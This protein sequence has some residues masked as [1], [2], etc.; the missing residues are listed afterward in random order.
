MDTARIYFAQCVRATKNNA[1]AFYNLALAQYL[2]GKRQEAIS[3]FQEAVR[4]RPHYENA[5]NN[6][7]VL[8]LEA[9]D[10][11]GATNVFAGLLRVNPTHENALLGMGRALVKLGDETQAKGYLELARSAEARLDLARLLEKMNRT[12]EA[13]LQFREA[14]RLHP[15]ISRQPQRW[16]GTPGRP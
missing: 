9:G 5:R 4:I 7:G 2:N 10:S 3:N 1:E 11:R 8:L 12:N 15:G 16:P 14:E 6:L 13:Q